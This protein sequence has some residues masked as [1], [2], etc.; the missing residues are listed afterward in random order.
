MSSNKISE[1]KKKSEVDYIPLCVN[2]WLSFNAWYKDE[3]KKFNNGKE[4]RDNQCIKFLKN[5]CDNGN[6]IY[7]TF[8]KLIQENSHF[9]FLFG[10]LHKALLNAE[11]YYNSYCGGRY[12]ISFE[13]VSIESNSKEKPSNLVKT[14][15]SRNKLLLCDNIFFTDNITLIYKAYIEIMY[16][17]RCMLIHGDLEMK[18]NQKDVIKYLYLIQYELMTDI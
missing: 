9:K 7:K 8:S 16:K 3:Y 18:D 6:I 12:S 4:G 2:L 5:K 14:K 10:S 15:R 13:N 1:W 11:L 17:I